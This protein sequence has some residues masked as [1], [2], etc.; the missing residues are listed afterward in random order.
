MPRQ[1]CKNM[2]RSICDDL[3]SRIVYESGAGRKNR[4]KV[5]RR[6]MN[7]KRTISSRGNGIRSRSA[8][9]YDPAIWLAGVRLRGNSEEIGMLLEAAHND[10]DDNDDDIDDDMHT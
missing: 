4:K 9:M 8:P 7:F 1:K 5:R 3:V 6:G 10:D 2:K